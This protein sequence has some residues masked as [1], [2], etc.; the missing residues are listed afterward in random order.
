MEKTISKEDLS[1]LPLQHFEGSVVVV[2]DEDCIDEFVKEL[3]KY[4]VIGFDTETRP[5]FRKGRIN[6]V[7]LLQFSANGKAYLFRLNK[8]G[9]HQSLIRLLENP[10]IIKVGVVIRD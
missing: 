2:E 10:E 5:S 6:K 1:L 7:S 9:L 8:T 3:E 4:P